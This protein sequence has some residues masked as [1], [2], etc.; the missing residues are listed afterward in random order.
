MRKN[1]VHNRLIRKLRDNKK[2]VEIH[3]YANFPHL[4]KSN[5][6]IFKNPTFAFI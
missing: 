6:Q 4:E 2:D 1:G 3:C 5:I